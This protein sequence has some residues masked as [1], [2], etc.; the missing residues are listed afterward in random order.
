MN[1]EVP[2]ADHEI[3]YWIRTRRSWF[4]DDVGLYR[5]ASSSAGVEFVAT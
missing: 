5:D 2:K 4:D 3:L 1:N